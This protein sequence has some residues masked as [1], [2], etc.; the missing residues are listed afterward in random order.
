MTLNEVMKDTADA[1]REK[2]GKSE[3]IAP[4]NFAEEIKSISAGGGESGGSDEWIYFDV[5]SP[6]LDDGYWAMIIAQYASSVKQADGGRVGFIGSVGILLMVDSTEARKLTI[7]I[8]INMSEKRY[9]PSLGS[10]LIS[11]K[12]YE[13]QTCQSIATTL[14]SLGCT[15]ITKEQFYDLNA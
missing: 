14:A 12:E 8:G 4:V 1:I 9:S 3:K 15:P 5:T 11:L 7:A 6:T 10:Q 13:V 2:T